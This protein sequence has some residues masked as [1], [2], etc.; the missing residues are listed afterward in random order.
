MRVVG[1]LRSFVLTI[2]L[3]HLRGIRGEELRSGGRRTRTETEAAGA[4]RT[5]DGSG[6]QRTAAPENLPRMTALTHVTLRER[7][8]CLDAA[9]EEIV[10]PLAE[11]SLSDHIRGTMSDDPH[12]SPMRSTT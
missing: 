3:S 6:R 9:A 5:G 4:C 2:T 10:I 1:Q 7:D 11:M 8:R 12:S